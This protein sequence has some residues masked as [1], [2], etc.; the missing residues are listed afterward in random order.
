MI[1]NLV[2]KYLMHDFTSGI[3]DELNNKNH[4]ETL[5]IIDIGC[6]RG[7]FS[8]N[9][10]KKIKGKPEK[11]IEKIIEKL[12]LQIFTFLTEGDLQGTK[13]V[14]NVFLNSN[15]LDK[16]FEKISR[17]VTRVAIGYGFQLLGKVPCAELDEPVHFL[18]TEV[19]TL[20]CHNSKGIKV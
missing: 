4:K 19:T 17:D 10:K 14:Y 1:Y 7:N 16:F 13:K 5:K 2:N 8:R 11:I 20:R 9:L 6:F 18:I 3:A 12:Q 15:S